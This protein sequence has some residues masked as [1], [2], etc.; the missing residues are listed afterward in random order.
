[1]TTYLTQ[2]AAAELLGWTEQKVKRFRL[3][4]KL[5]YIPGRPPTIARDDIEALKCLRP[6]GS[7]KNATP[8][9]GTPAGPI[10]VREV[11]EAEADVRLRARRTWLKLRFGSRNGS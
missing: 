1:M 10:P 4:G 7:S 8:A 11:K 3:G 2:S 6:P 5:P 9:S